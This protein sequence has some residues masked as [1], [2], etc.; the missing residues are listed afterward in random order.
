MSFR[1]TFVHAVDQSVARM[2]MFGIHFMPVWAYTLAA[3]LSEL[4]DLELRL[5]DL[6]VGEL[7]PE[8]SPS[9]VYLFTGINQ[10]YEAIMREAKRYRERAPKAKIVLGGP[11][12]WSYETAGRID[13]LEWF[14]HLFVGDGEETLPAFLRDLRAGKT[15]PKIIRAPGRFNLEKAKPMHDGLLRATVGRYYGGV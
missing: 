15:L 6:R 13:K 8:G 2:Q 14:D 11:I 9:D 3:H 1:V 12:C 7:E 10:D 4:P 5:D